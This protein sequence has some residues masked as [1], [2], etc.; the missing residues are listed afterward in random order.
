[1]KITGTVIGTAQG[2]KATLLLIEYREGDKMITLA[3][4]CYEGNRELEGQVRG[5]ERGEVIDVVGTLASRES[6]G[7]W[8][9]SF[10]AKALTVV[11]GVDRS[12]AQDVAS[13][14]DFL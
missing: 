13:D 8:Y 5:L 12:V 14:D 11:K 1:M 9:T 2:F 4:R 6:K 10:E 3:V 7:Q